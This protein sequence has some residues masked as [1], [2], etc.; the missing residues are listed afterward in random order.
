MNKKLVS[1]FSLAAIVF[2]CLVFAGN[3]T[4]RLTSGNV[5]EKEIYS[6]AVAS[7]ILSTNSSATSLLSFTT[8]TKA[9]TTKPP[10]KPSSTPP[11][12]PAAPDWCQPP[13][14]YFPVP[15][16]PGA[17]NGVHVPGICLKEGD[18]RHGKQEFRLCT[19]INR[20]SVCYV[21]KIT[22]EASDKPCKIEVTTPFFD[23]PSSY[24]PKV[25]CELKPSLPGDP[26]GLFRVDCHLVDPTIS[27]EIERFC[28]TVDPKTL[29]L[30]PQ[31][32]PIPPVRPT[33]T[34]P[35]TRDLI[36][37]VVGF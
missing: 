23:I 5:A 24:L 25:K 3:L 26:S 37:P 31:E 29:K 10:E 35:P 30:M 32:C 18:V 33:I 13:A 28:Y 8:A 21:I 16:F 7:V 11:T 20:T 22:C 6:K 36:P 4:V 2:V 34:T 14:Q 1:F 19:I 27:P 9:D 15:N 17:P 12:T